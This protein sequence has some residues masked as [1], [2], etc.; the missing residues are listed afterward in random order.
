MPGNSDKTC[1][2]FIVSCAGRALPTK[3]GLVCDFTT[4]Q[5]EAWSCLN[6]EAAFHSTVYNS[7][8]NGYRPCLNVLGGCNS[9]APLLVL[10]SLFIL[11]L[12][13]SFEQV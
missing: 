9:C 1:E 6:A 7:K 12:W 13:Y 11:L 3:L 8:E 10:L 2:S 5:S 4:S